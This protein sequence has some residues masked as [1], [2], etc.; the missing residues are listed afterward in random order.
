MFVTDIVVWLNSTAPLGR[1][2][3]RALS[4]GLNPE[5][6]RYSS[7]YHLVVTRIGPCSQYLSLVVHTTCY[8]VEDGIIQNY[9]INNSRISVQ[10]PTIISTYAVGYI[11]I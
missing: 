6:G 10:K 2:Y 1:A 7:V 4:T 11:T 3:R 5:F 8:S 9:D